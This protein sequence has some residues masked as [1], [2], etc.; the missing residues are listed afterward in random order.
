MF[1]FTKTAIPE[2]ILIEPE[3]FG[4]NRGFFLET[5][6]KSEFAKNGINVDFVQDNHSKSK[7]GVLRGLHFQVGESAQA[8]LVRCISGEIFD[9]AVDIR[10]D[11]PTFLKWVGYILSA[12]NKNQ[13]FIPADGFAHGFCVLSEEAEIAYK[14]SKEYDPKSERGII[15]NDELIGIKWPIKDPILSDKDLKNITIKDI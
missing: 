12:E 7:T 8:K 2:V 15:W 1:K 14:C 5:Y 3:I 11:S 6:K 4:D 9:V 13:L 10:K